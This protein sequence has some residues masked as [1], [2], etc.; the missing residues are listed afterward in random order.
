[1]VESGGPQA[2]PRRSDIDSWLAVVKDG[3]LLPESI[4]RTLCSKLKEILVEESN[5]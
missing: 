3:G 2:V 5:V 1:M 4:F